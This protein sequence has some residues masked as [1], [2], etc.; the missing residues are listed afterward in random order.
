MFNDTLMMRA[1]YI[2]WPEPH[3]LMSTPFCVAFF[4]FSSFLSF[5][6]FSV[7]HNNMQEFPLC[8]VAYLGLLPAFENQKKEAFIVT[9]PMTGLF[10]AQRE[11]G[12]SLVSFL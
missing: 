9:A 12:S 8:G 5:L 2:M 4:D 6:F 11:L 3:L 1:W 10:K 7:P